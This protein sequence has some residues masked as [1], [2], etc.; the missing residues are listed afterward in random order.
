[1]TD[2]VKEVLIQASPATIF[3]FLADPREFIKW[4]GTDVRL[5]G[6]TRR[7]V[8]RALRKGGTAAGTFLEVA[9]DQRVVFTFW[10]WIC[11]ATRFRRGPPQ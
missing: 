9:A 1:M 10:S 3:T 7:R 2:A 6:P 5:G 11:R 8:L 4:M